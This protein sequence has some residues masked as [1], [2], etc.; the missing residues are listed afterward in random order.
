MKSNPTYRSVGKAV[1]RVE[2]VE[3]VTGKTLFAADV[4]LP[5][6]LWGKVLRSSQPHARIVKVD[7]SKARRFPGVHVVLSGADLPPLLIGSRM[8][9][10]PVLARD[11]VRFAGEPV[12]ALAAESREI[13]EEAL[14]LIEVEYEELPAVFDPVRA[15]DPGAP[16]L[17]EDR[18]RYKNAPPVPEG[19]PNLQSL[20][21]WKNG[22]LEQGF[23]RAHRTFEHTFCAQ[24]THHGYL[25]PHACAVRIDPSGRV[26]VWAANKSPY[27]LRDQLAEDLGV[28]KERIKV[29]IMPVGGDFGGKASL[30]DVPICYFL[31]E[32][33][34]RPVKL[35]L[36]YSEELMAAAHR[37]PGRITLRTGV[38]EDG[39]LT[40]IEAK[41]V[42]GGGAY[43]AF[44]INP[45]VTVLG[46]RRLAS[47]YR[48]PAI[49]VETYCAYTNQVPCTQTRTPGSPQIVFA[50]ESQMDI[51]AKELGLDPVELRS[52]N[53]LEEGDPSPMGERWQ[54]ILAGE[55]LRRA[56]EASGWGKRKPSKYYGRG[57][58]LYER[59]TPSGKASAAIS[60]DV[61]GSVTVLTGC[62][63]VGPGFYTVI[64]QFV[65]ETLGAP[66]DRVRVRFED[67]DA[68]PYDPG[69][70]GSKSTNTSGHAAHKA[71]QELRQ[72]LVAVAARRLGRAPEEIRQQGGRFLAPGCKPMAY[73]ELARLA[74]AENGGPIHHLTMYEPKEEPPVTA[75][76]AQVAEVEVDPETG[77]VVVKRI[78]TAHDAGR[79]LNRLTFEGQVDGGVITGLGLALMEETPMVDG[80]IATLNMAD[81]KIPC[82]KDIPRLKIVTIE[83]PTGP[84]P[85]QGKAIAE[86]PNVPTPA[87]IANAIADAV[88]VRIFELPI[89]AEKIYRALQGRSP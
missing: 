34:G 47:Y 72:R 18:A 62:P 85:F 36:D 19:I 25:E 16:L 28:P 15:M 29:H 67:T 48:V 40:A 52:K 24:L 21:V 26:E 58:A 5:G 31:A 38:E 70:G 68:L 27:V 75:F 80:R 88:G 17:H 14:N 10:M 9:D 73:S 56:V 61:D 63:D 46:G 74:V 39:T 45:Q 43:A 50:M 13:A 8:K 64:Q 51:I 86:M 4:K 54:H 83:S 81:F 23:Q 37:H 57:V 1:P 65:S 3:K 55:T 71:A 12:A 89:T 7:A 41:V 87:A 59:G 60:L 42:F 2:G 49:R 6:A 22:D 69:T 77:K 30:I 20:T 33:S 79:V 82:A 32:R 78:T 35:V 66:L 44:K 11:R 76:A 84:V 53:L